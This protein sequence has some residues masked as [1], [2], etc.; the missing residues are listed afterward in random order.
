VRILVCIIGELFVTNKIDKNKNLII[1]YFPEA[2]AAKAAAKKLK[3]WDKVTKD[4]KLA[5]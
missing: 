5:G 1:A 2:K 4:I 3:Q